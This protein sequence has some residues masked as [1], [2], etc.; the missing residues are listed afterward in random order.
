METRQNS[1]YMLLESAI[2]YENA[3]YRLQED[4]S[5]YMDYFFGGDDQDVST[6]TRK[7]W[8]KDLV[9]GPPEVNDWENAKYFLEF[10]KVFYKVTMKIS[11]S[12]YLTSI[13]FSMSLSKYMLIL[14]KCALVKI[15]DVVTWQGV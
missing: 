12:K 3:F 15:L 9:V 11:G 5:T 14:E 6:N 4:N 10:L 8:K 2:K 13:F 1:T 7:R